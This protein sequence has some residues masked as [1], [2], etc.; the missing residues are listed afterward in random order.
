MTNERLT[1]HNEG[2]RPDTDDDAEGHARYKAWSDENV[3]HDVEPVTF[4]T[5]QPKPG[6]PATK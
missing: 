5:P 3:K 4:P 2:D 6:R 1:S